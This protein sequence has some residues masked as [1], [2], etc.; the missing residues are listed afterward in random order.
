MPRG[1]RTGPA[2]AGPMT[3][4]GAGYCAGFPAPGFAQRFGGWGGGWGGGWRGRGRGW[5]WGMGPVYPQYGYASA[6]AEDTL[7]ALRAQEGWL[8]EQLEALQKRIDAL[9]GKEKA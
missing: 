7:Q 6:P 1:D 3:G 5:G 4:R 8:R 9:E 2:G